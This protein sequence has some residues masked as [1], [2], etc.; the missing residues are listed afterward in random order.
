MP[1]TIRQTSGATFKIDKL[2]PDENENAR[3]ER[4]HAG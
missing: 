4:N 1:L 3:D 2:T